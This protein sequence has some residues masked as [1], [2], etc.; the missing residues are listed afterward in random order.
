MPRG[1]PTVCVATISAPPSI[2]TAATTFT[3]LKL[4]P[5]ECPTPYPT[6]PTPSSTFSLP[7]PHR[8]LPLRPCLVLTLPLMVP[9]SSVGRSSTLTSVYVLFPPSASL[10]SSA[11]GGQPYCRS[12]PHPWYASHPR[13]H[14]RLWQI[15][16]FLRHRS[17]P[18]VS[19]FSRLTSL[20]TWST[21]PCTEPFCFSS[22]CTHPPSRSPSSCPRRSHSPCPPSCRHRR[23]LL[24]C[25]PFLCHTV[26][27]LHVCSRPRPLYHFN[28]W[29][30]SNF[31]GWQP[32]EFNGCPP[33][34][35]T[36]SLSCPHR[37]RSFHH[38]PHPPSCCYCNH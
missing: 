17:R 11:R 2:T 31:N 1:P 18:L 15:P 7:S 34:P 25:F 9:T 32:S 16:L 12:L 21:F 28:G 30:P 23:C 8:H 26:L 20:T 13:V 5:P 38:V 29:S 36:A 10:S 19:G 14:L 27:S 37:R 33:H 4:A 6:F 22:S 24:S 3:Y 35:Q